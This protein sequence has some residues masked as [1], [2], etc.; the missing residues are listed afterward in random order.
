MAAPAS[1][2]LRDLVF[3]LSPA[4]L[5]L[6]PLPHGLWAGVMEFYVRETWVSLVVIV[7]GTTSLYFGSGGG[8]IGSGGHEAVRTAAR[9][10]LEA[11]DASAAAFAPASAYPLPAKSRIHFYALRTDGVYASPDFEERELTGSGDS[12]LPLYA[13]AQDLIA[14]IR[15]ATPARG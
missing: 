13:A 12:L 10:F 3:T 6:T 7:D 8:I 1:A 11:M 14:Q 2:R 15:L 5:K 4:Q 9:S